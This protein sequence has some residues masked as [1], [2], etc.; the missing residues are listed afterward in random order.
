MAKKTAPDEL[1]K[2]IEELTDVQ[3]KDAI[4]RTCIRQARAES[5]LSHYKETYGEVIKEEKEMRTAYLMALEVRTEATRR[6]NAAQGVIDDNPTEELE[7]A[8]NLMRLV[9]TQQ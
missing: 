1:T 8:E 6:Q 7:K 2:K 3:L 5:D 4:V 9:E